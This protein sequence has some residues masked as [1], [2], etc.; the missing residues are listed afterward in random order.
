MVHMDS[1]KENNWLLLECLFGFFINV[2]GSC[3]QESPIDSVEVVASRD[4]PSSLML[5]AVTPI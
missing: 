3:V 5:T 4:Q 2:L 1:W